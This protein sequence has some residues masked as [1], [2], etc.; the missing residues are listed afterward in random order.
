VASRTRIEAPSPTDLRGDPVR[1][2]QC[3]LLI[4]TNAEKYAPHGLIT[5]TVRKDGV[6]GLI[7]ITDEGPGIPDNEKHLVLK[8]YYRS[9]TTKNLPG[10]GLGLHIANVLMTSMHGHIKLTSPPTGG[11]RATLSMP[12]ASPPPSL[13]DCCET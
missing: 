6:Y 13:S 1:L 9:P 4:L 5:V 8:P 7:E 10:S 2:R 12:L 11:L 3:L